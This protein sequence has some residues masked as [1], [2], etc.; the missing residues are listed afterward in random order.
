MHTGW[1]NTH[2]CACYPAIYNSFSSNDLPAEYPLMVAPPEGLQPQNTALP[3]S[4]SVPLISY[5]AFSILKPFFNYPHRKSQEMPYSKAIDSLKKSF[6]LSITGDHALQYAKFFCGIF[7][8]YSSGFEPEDGI[9]KSLSERAKRVHDGIVIYHNAEN[10]GRIERDAALLQDACILTV[11][12]QFPDDNRF[13]HLHI[14]DGTPPPPTGKSWINLW[15]RFIRRVETEQNILYL[16]KLNAKYDARFN[17]VVRYGKM[18]LSSSRPKKIPP[19]INYKKAYAAITAQKNVSRH[20]AKWCAYLLASFELVL[21]FFDNERYGENEYNSACDLFIRLCCKEDMLSADISTFSAYISDCFEN[22]SI[23]VARGEPNP[24]LPCKGWYDPQKD[25]LY[26]PYNSY[27]E[28]FLSFCGIHSITAPEKTV[29]QSKTLIAHD[30]VRLRP[31][32]QGQRPD[33]KVVVAPGA[34]SKPENI[35]TILLSN[36]SKHCPLT[37]SAQQ[38]CNELALCSPPRR[39]S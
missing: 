19:L 22:G 6:A 16:K 17:P 4:I 21:K 26:L 10:W 35:I 32:R 23:L 12:A 24:G 36:M 31:N 34:K 8:E 7:Q 29:Y 20:K 27:Y 5:T 33:G 13:L 30:V 11:N 14:P 2:I 25:Y 9:Y 37:E 18:Q 38:K 39:W 1:I 3:R 15:I 28:D